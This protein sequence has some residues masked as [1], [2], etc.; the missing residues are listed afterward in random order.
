MFERTTSVRSEED[1]HK[2]LEDVCRT[3]AD[4]LGYNAVVVNVYRPAYDDMLTASAVGSEASVQAL[5]GKA[6]PAETWYPLLAERFERR[7]AYFI[8]GEEFDWD[9]LG[10]D[11][12]VP[13]IAPSD[14]PE[15]LDRGG[16]A[17]RASLRQPGRAHRRHLGGRAADRTAAG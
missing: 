2:V 4:L 12:F 16:R 9:E 17:V 8:P 6:S 7:G 13:D 10:V 15:R 5:V 11:T 3:I 14:D 1:L